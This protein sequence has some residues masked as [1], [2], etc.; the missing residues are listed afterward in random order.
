ME[1]VNALVVMSLDELVQSVL[2]VAQQNV[3]G[4]V[5][6]RSQLMSCRVFLRDKQKAKYSYFTLTFPIQIVFCPSLQGSI[7]QDGWS[8]LV[9]AVEVA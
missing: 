7:C 9:R 8:S 3:K 1:I 6:H 5:L 2:K 4:A